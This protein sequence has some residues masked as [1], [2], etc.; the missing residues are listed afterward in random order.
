MF[1]HSGLFTYYFRF[2]RLYGISF[3]FTDM[4]IFTGRQDNVQS[5]LA[6][7]PDQCEGKNALA[8]KQNPL[9]KRKGF[10]LRVLSFV[11]KQLAIVK[12]NKLM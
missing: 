7:G 3:I 10:V 6:A 8:K 12:R 2:S 5:A 11:F 1:S 4:A 9:L